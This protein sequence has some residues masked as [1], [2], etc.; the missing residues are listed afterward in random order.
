MGMSFSFGE[1]EYNKIV[2][3]DVIWRFVAACFWMGL[4]EF[5]DI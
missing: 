3:L 4:E 1:S 5:P 2:R